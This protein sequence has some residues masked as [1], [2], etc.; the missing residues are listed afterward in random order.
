[1]FVLILVM[2]YLV[3]IAG[4]CNHLADEEIPSCFT[5]IFLLMFYGGAL[6]WSAVFD[7]VI[8]NCKD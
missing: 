1:M 6:G 3:S 4:C 2:K 7:C 8:R 5:L